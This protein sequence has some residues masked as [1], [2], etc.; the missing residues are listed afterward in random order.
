[1]SADEQEYAPWFKI[2]GG[3][4]KQGPSREHVDYGD[5]CL[6]KAGGIIAPRIA[7]SPVL[8][9]R[10]YVLRS[11]PNGVQVAVE[12]KDT[13]WD[14]RALWRSRAGARWSRRWAST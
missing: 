10:F 9:G 7:A 3:K 4:H 6:N 2:H 8:T 13:R 12:L 1:M 5:R 14:V 11:G